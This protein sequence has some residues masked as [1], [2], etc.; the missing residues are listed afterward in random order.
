LMTFFKNS[1]TYWRFLKHNKKHLR[2]QPSQLKISEIV[3][4]IN[5]YISTF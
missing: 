1:I 5:L 2:M 3:F 4:I